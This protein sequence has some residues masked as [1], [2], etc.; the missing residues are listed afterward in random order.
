MIRKQTQASIGDLRTRTIPA[1]PE[2]L[3]MGA[4]RKVATLK[5]VG[6]L[7]VEREGRLIGVLDERVLAEA[8]DDADVAETMAPIGACLHPAMSAGRAL[9]LFMRE[10]VS[11]LPV[12]LGMCAL[13][14]LARADVE[15]LLARQ[16]ASTRRRA[17]RLRAAA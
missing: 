16:R 6:V 10:R 11:V 13:G 4:A 12:A 14:A 3:A 2:H 1:V 9:E 15:Q 8:A 5:R 7:F 17:V